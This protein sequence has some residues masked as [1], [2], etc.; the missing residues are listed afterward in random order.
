MKARLALRIAF[1]AAALADL[2]TGCP[3][4]ESVTANEAGVSDSTTPEEAATEGS[5][6]EDTGAGTDGRRP[7][8]SADATLADTSA[9]DT[10]TQDSTVDTDVTDAGAD[11]ASEMGAADSGGADAGGD[12]QA[13]ASADAGGDGGGQDAAADVGADMGADTAPDAGAD[14]GQDAGVG[15]GPVCQHPDGG[16]YFCNAG[17][18]CCANA[19]T[20]D[21]NC[22]ASCD[23]GAGY[24]PVDCPGSSGDGGCG[25]LVID[26]G[27]IPNCN[28]TELT[29]ACGT[30]CNDNPPSALSG[31]VGSYTIQLCTA[32]AD[33][34]GNPNGDTYCCNFGTPPS[35]VNWCVSQAIYLTGLW[36]SCL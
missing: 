15:Q 26:G 22:A 31:C 9:T 7:D 19:V 32:A 35:P 25:T 2:L 5:N 16:N 23:Q 30:T 34:A 20:R 8:A 14:A 6:G 17:Q 3:S 36:N 24:Y 33:C 27:S 28:P 29:S 13:E 18:H 4:S 11:S 10:G 12:A 21:S 1:V